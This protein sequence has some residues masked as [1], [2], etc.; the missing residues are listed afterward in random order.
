MSNNLQ[1]TGGA[2]VQLWQSLPTWGKVVTGI[3]AV[4]GLYY[5]FFFI[6]GMVFL[7]AMAIGLITIVRW[8]LR[9]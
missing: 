9:R 2:A 7:A 5:G 4:V 6:L 1:R 3:A 8:L